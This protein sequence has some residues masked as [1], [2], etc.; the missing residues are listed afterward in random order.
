MSLREA[1]VNLAERVLPEAALR[2]LGIGALA[3]VGAGQGID[4]TP[5]PESG[6]RKEWLEERWRIVSAWDPGADEALRNRPDIW[7]HDF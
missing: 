2:R 6:S 7:T 3:G 4:L 1:V 5:S